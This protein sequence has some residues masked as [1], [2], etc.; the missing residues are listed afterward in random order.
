MR[1]WTAFVEHGDGAEALV[2]PEILR[3]WRRSQP[4]VPRDVTEAPLDDESAAR[5]FWRNSPL[6]EAVSRVE[7]ELRRTARTATWSWP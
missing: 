5:E 7:S 1:A 4:H 3:S 6:Q 2:R